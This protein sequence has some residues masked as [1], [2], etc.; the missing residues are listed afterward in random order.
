MTKRIGLN[1]VMA[2]VI[3]VGLVSCAKDEKSAV[4]EAIEA[5]EAKSD[6]LTDAETTDALPEI[7]EGPS[8]EELAQLAA[9]NTAEA[10]QYFAEYANKEGVIATE[11]GLLYE[12]LEEGPKDGYSPSPTDIVD[13]HFAMTTIDGIEFDS[14]RARGSAARVRVDQ[15]FLPGVVEGLQLMSIGDHFRFSMPSEL[16]FGERGAGP[17]E[18]NAAIIFDVELLN[19]TNPERNLEQATAFL[20]GNKTKK[21]IIT[22]DSGLQYEIISEGP[23]DGKSPTDVNKVKVDYEGKLVNGTI[24]DSSYAR[25]E[26]IVFGVTQVISG[27]TEGLQLMSEGDKFRFFI[28]PALAYGETGT[29]PV[30]GPNEALIFEVELHEVQ[31]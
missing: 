12:V 1:A 14:S 28:P 18:P 2:A 23:S 31:S 27:W 19:V 6:T 16:A 26:P 17:V 10:E 29:G 11:S 30:I 8:A 5:E 24:F 22:T 3:G 7:P 20:A 25:G 4:A 13:M 9:D 21:G 15:T